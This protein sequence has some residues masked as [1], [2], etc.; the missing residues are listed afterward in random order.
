[1]RLRTI[2]GQRKRVHG[3][4]AAAI[5]LFAALLLSGCCGPRGAYPQPGF[6]GVPQAI[7]R[8]AD[9]ALPLSAVAREE[10]VQF[11]AASGNRAVAQDDPPRTGRLRQ[12]E[13]AYRPI[14][15]RLQQQA[16]ALAELREG[17]GFTSLFDT[18]TL[19]LVV[20]DARLGWDGI[21]F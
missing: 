20:H 13:A 9:F 5:L 6:A 2:Q 16:P 1:M 15:D 10:L 7:H 12:I 14:L 21:D 18:N 17:S 19:L 3:I 8:S 11:M 4:R